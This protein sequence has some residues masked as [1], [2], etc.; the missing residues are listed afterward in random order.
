MANLLT[1]RFAA[2]LGLV[3]AL[4]GCCANDVCDP[5]DPLEDA[6]TLRFSRDFAPSD[7]D[8]V[9]VLRSPRDSTTGT[10]PENV[11]LLRN[12]AQ[13]YDDIVLNNGA[14]FAQVGNAKLGGYRYVVQYLAHPNKANKGVVTSALF[15]KNLHVQGEFYKKSACCTNY[16]N[17]TKTVV[18]RG[19]TVDL[20]KNPVVEVPKPK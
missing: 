15:L 1:F 7:L 6:I 12:S 13:A 19:Q 2:L 4:G 14:P 17:V 11:T 10:R 5:D 8:T 18:I 9:I 16:R 3:A 20:S